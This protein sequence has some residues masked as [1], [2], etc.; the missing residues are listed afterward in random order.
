ML[1]NIDRFDTIH[2]LVEEIDDEIEL[3]FHEFFAASYANHFT[4]LQ[5]YQNKHHNIPKVSKY[6]PFTL[7][8]YLNKLWAL[9]QI[10]FVVLNLFIV[11]NLK[12]LLWLV[13]LSLVVVVVLL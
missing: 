2:V 11:H 4:P 5:R 13:V 3:F 7:Q 9:E 12:A 10:L 6:A 1:L 8:K